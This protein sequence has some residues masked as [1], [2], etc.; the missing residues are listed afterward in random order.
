LV[1]FP[2]G[3]E[4]TGFETVFGE[5]VDVTAGDGDGEAIGLISRGLN[6]CA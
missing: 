1:S 6:F 4:D 2:L 3:E 5:D